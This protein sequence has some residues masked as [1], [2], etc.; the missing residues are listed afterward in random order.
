MKRAI[1]LALAALLVAAGCGGGDDG[2]TVDLTMDSRVEGGSI[3]VDGTT[4]LPDGA[5]VDYEITHEAFGTIDDLD[6]PTWDLFADGSVPVT[7]GTYTIT[8]PVPDWPP[9]D[10]TVW[11]A[12]QVTLASDQPAGV[13][14]RY[15]EM[16]KKLGGSNVTESAGLRR[17]ELEQTVRL[18]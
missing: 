1:G 13:V 2:Q 8:T 7:A 14:E 15:G 18:G 3:V 11:V 17:V 4:D 16:G 5:L 12:F 6:D 10:V 9:G